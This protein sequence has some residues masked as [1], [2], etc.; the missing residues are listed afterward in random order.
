LQLKSYRSDY[1]LGHLEEKADVTY[2]FFTDNPE[3]PELGQS[4]VVML[5]T[6]RSPKGWIPERKLN[7][8]ES[9]QWLEGE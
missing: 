6:T 4:D 3:D 9:S 1:W 5:N 7:V 2:R 8:D